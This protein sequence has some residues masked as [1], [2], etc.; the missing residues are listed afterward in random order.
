[1]PPGP[2]PEI[3]PDYPPPDEEPQPA[4]I[5]DAPHEPLPA[6]DPSPVQPEP[7]PDPDPLEPPEEAPVPA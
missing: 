2:E 5:P 6:E 3:V 7:D 4:V 1:M